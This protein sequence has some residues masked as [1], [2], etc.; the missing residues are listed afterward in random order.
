[1]PMSDTE[2]RVLGSLLEK[3]RTTPEQYPLTTNSLVLACNQKT[4]RDP[5]TNYTEREVTDCL[6]GLRDRG[7]VVTTRADHERVYK[8]R[9]Q[10]ERAFFLGP[11]GFA[12]LA[13]LMLRG[14][15]TPGELRTRTERYVSFSDMA[16]VEA[17]LQKLALHQPPLAKNLG[18]GP[19]Q[20][21]DRWS[22]TLGV[23]EEKQRPRARVAKETVSELEDLRERVAELEA[24]L[25]RV[26]AH[27][28]WDDSDEA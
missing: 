21:Q 3:E 5:V 15:Q 2:L 20:S 10:L 17:N 24:R 11:K 7:L 25:Q 26:Y 4:N 19:G 14:P 28:G 12:L 1:M 16:D 23:D 8:H 9:H 22:H 27:L 6:Q 13:V 18:R